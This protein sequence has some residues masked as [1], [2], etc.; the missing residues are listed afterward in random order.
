MTAVLGDQTVHAPVEDSVPEAEAVEA[1]SNSRFFPVRAMTRPFDEDRG[2]DF[3]AVLADLLERF[4]E[5]PVQQ[6]VRIAVR[7]TSRYHHVV[8]LK[9]ECMIAMP[10]R[11][12]MANNRRRRHQ[13]PR[14]L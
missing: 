1:S 2:T 6:L 10:S 4:P 9:H 12:Y 7:A 8:R 14:F 11:Q 13:D 5:T 3:R